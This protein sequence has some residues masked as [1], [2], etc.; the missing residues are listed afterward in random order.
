[1]A[2]QVGGDLSKIQTGPSKV[3]YKS[4]NVGHTMGGVK[5]GFKPDL[6]KRMVDEYGTHV[7][8]MIYQG[9]DATVK[10]TVAE[11]TMA[12]IQF[13]YQWGFSITSV[14][15]G[16]GKTPG[17]KASALAGALVLHPL[18]LAASTQEDVTIYKAFVSDTGEV[19]FGTITADRVF[20]VT[21]TALVDE[22]QT[23]H[24]LGKIGGPTP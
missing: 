9:E 19:E 8:D 15:W 11:K 24:L 7:S 5:F 22:S 12:T 18:D 4:A 14:S 17:T 6:R 13:V 20:E 10:L 21:M 3:T 23:G 2:S 1:M 16:I